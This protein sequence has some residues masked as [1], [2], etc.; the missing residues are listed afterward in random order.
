MLETINNLLKEK[1]KH[2]IKMIFNRQ[3]LATW[4]EN[5]CD[6]NCIT[7]ASKVYTAITGEKILCPCGSNKL[8]TLISIRDG[9]SFCGRAAVC[10]SARESVSKNCA[11]AS[12]NWD[13][14]TAK[15]KRRFTNKALYGVENI[16]QSSIAKTAHFNTYQDRDRVQEILSQMQ[17]TC[18]TRYG[19]RNIANIPAVAM[20]RAESKRLSML[21]NYG[22][23]HETQI[24][25]SDESFYILNDKN[26]FTE[27]LLQLGRSKMAEKLGVAVTTISRHHNQFGLNIISQF[28]STY[29]FEIT[30]WFRRIG[31]ESKKDKTICKPKELDFYIPSHNLAIEFDG[32]Y[33]HSETQ[34]KDRNYHINKTKQCRE[35]EIQLI[36][37]FEDEWL[38]KKDV[39]KSIISGLLNQ[40]RI[41][42]PARKCA[43]KEVSN[44]EIKSFLDE[45]HLQGHINASKNIVLMYENEIVAGM[46]FG[47]PRYNKQI[48]WELLRLVT[49]CDTHII[50]GAQKLWHNF[51]KIEVP[52]SIVSYC[53]RRWFTGRIYETLGFIKKEEAKPTYW[54]TDYEQRFHRSKFTKKN[55]VKTATAVDPTLLAEEVSKLS[56]RQ[57]TKN[58][59]GLDRIWDCGQDSWIW[60]K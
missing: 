3:D 28:T 50:G 2:A 40:T 42:I 15:E 58:I 47:R 12:K 25:I 17:T 46:S 56:E 53:D 36:H 19:V 18:L 51:Q 49:K 30:D 23:P 20:K 29:E 52:T 31:I 45:N 44:R 41:T 16:G 9:F 48:D 38:H 7:N 13:K 22:R 24:H 10:S 57:I 35:Q 11:L 39:C 43:I 33:W 5:H 6:P 4:I 27:M 59:L 26:K 32:L 37:I 55:C 34:G 14:E 1:P 21:S 8:R 54:Y 60:K